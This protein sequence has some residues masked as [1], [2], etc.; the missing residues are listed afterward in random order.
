MT[1]KRYHVWMPPLMLAVVIGIAYF[2]VRGFDRPQMYLTILKNGAYS[3]ILALGILFVLICGDIDLSLGAQ[4][5][6][7]GVLCAVCLKRGV[8][9]LLAILLTLAAA[10]FVGC[11]L[12]TAVGRWR[13][14][15]MIAT[16]AMSVTLEGLTFILAGGVPVY[17]LPDTFEALAGHKLLQLPQ[18]TLVWFLLALLTA[19]VLHQTYWGRFFYAVGCNAAAAEKTGV[20]IAR[21]KTA[22]FALCSLLCGICSVVYIAQIGLAPLEDSSDINISVLTIAA[23]GGVSFSGGRGRV[24]PVFCAAVLLSAL[25]SM[26]IVLRVP[27]Y[28]QNCIKG[29]IIFV[30]VLTKFRKS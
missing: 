20:S 30:A 7:Y 3:G 18:P 16:I 6:F 19:L 11:F 25:T 2:T 13:V 27:P 23:L 5:C 22:A 9:I 1:R 21:T 26:F 28:Y 12:G 4:M 10:L 8:P 17:N 24:V 29:A 14:N 15:S